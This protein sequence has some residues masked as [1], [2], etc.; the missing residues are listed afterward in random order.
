MSAG[1]RNIP[2]CLPIRHSNTPDIAT[3]RVNDKLQSVDTSY[4]IFIAE[5]L[6]GLSLLSAIAHL[7]FALS[8]NHVTQ[9]SLSMKLTCPQVLHLHTLVGIL[10]RILPPAK[11]LS[12]SQTMGRLPPSIRVEQHRRPAPIQGP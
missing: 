7:A 6:Y 3:L 8:C 12:R 9:T 1:Y 4:K 5:I 10:S 11:S 2:G